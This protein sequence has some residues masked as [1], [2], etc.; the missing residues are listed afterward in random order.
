MSRSRPGLV[1]GSASR[2]VGDLP[3]RRGTPYEDERLAEWLVALMMVC[4]V[5]VLAGFAAIVGWGG[6]EPRPP[7]STRDPNE[8]LS[9]GVVARRYLWYVTVAVVSGLASG[10]MLAGAGGRLAMRLL[11]VTAGD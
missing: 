9:P 11:A 5:L 3:P 2:R 1:S 6:L 10:I 8:A 7:W 4:G